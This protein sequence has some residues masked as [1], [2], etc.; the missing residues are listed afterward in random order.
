MYNIWRAWYN[1]SY[2]MMAKAMRDV[3]L[4]YLIVQFL[5]IRISSREGGGGGGGGHHPHLCWVKSIS[6]YF[7]VILSLTNRFHVDER[8]FSNKSWM[9]SKCS[10]NKCNTS[11]RRVCHGC[12]YHILTFSVI[13][14]WTD[15]RQH[16]IYLFYTM[17][18]KE[19]RPIHIPASY[20][21]TVR[22][23]VLV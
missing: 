3:E 19:N 6:C 5:T 2:T 22:G 13:Y 14:Y 21:L 16:G 18:R 10:K 7:K 12:F 9:T 8:L 23:F 15:Q 20:R 11:R 4:Y 17:I 1:G